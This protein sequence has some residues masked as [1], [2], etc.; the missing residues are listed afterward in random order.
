[1]LT[2]LYLPFPQDAV[3]RPLGVSLLFEI[4]TSYSTC[5]LFISLWFVGKLLPPSSLA[6]G[7]GS[8]FL[9]YAPPLPGTDHYSEKYNY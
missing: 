4:L 8:Q 7:V 3:H 5:L 2:L 6:L 1:M 9:Q